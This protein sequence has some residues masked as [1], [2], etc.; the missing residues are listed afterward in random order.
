MQYN[1]DEIVLSGGLD[2]QICFV[3]SVE[4]FANL[5]PIKLSPFSHSQQQVQVSNKVGNGENRYWLLMVQHSRHV[6]LFKL[7]GEVDSKRPIEKLVS[8]HHKMVVKR[9][10]HLE[11]PE[12]LVAL[13]FKNRLIL[14]SSALSGG[15]FLGQSLMNKQE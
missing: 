1:G 13:Y 10:N 12:K 14:R 15:E 5:R 2:T 7:Q 8:P 3:E 11:T 9:H 4:K 6:E